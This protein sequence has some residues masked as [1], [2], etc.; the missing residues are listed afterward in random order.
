AMVHGNKLDPKKDVT[1]T[2]KIFETRIELSI[3][4]MGQG[5]SPDEVPDPTAPENILKDS[6]RGIYI[7]RSFIDDVFYNFTEEGTELNLIIQINK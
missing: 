4:D 7:L 3:K 6:G 5:F 2:I 1:I